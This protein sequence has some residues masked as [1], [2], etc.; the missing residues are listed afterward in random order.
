MKKK[1]RR[2]I[3]KAKQCKHHDVRQNVFDGLME[4]HECGEKF[5]WFINTKKRQIEFL[6]YDGRFKC[7]KGESIHGSI[8]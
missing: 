8:K 3:K 7:L 1:K 4:C 5:D 2:R 6:P